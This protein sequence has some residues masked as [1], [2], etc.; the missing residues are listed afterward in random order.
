[1]TAFD[2]TEAMS[3]GVD[4]LDHRHRDLIEHLKGLVRLS[5]SE[6]T[7]FEAEAGL[8]RFVKRTD[9][10]FREEEA[11]MRR[12]CPDQ[13]PTHRGLH[14]ALLTQLNWVVDEAVATGPAGFAATIERSIAPGLIAH[15]VSED[16]KI[17]AGNPVIRDRRLGEQR[18]V[19]DRRSGVERRGN[20][21]Q[22]L[23][24]SDSRTG[25]GRRIADRRTRVGR[26][27]E[28]RLTWI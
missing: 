3:C 23:P 28:E 9:L 2:W 19:I 4:Y 7:A 5:S 14:A 27:L 10:Y 17:N 18:T 16:V 22:S 21:A 26:R 11:H 13:L 12:H 15:I 6:D 8:M 20:G 1:M 25:T 24:F